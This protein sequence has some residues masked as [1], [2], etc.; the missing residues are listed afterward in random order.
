MSIFSRLTLQRRSG[1][2]K[3]RRSSA[4]RRTRFAPVLDGL[5]ARALLSNIV[6]TNND[7]SGPGS[8]RQAIENCAEWGDDLICKQLEGRD[9]HAL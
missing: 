3:S 6:V 1:Q 9:H 8:L 2:H 4:K 7:D 5:E